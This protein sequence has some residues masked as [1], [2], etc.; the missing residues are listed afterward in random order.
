MTKDE[1]IQLADVYQ[2]RYFQNVF[3][4]RNC[5]AERN[6][7]RLS[8]LAWMT[9]H[10]IGFAE[11]GKLAKAERWIRFIQGALWAMGRTT[12]DTFSADNRGECEV[13]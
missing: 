5:D 1:V 4:V 13:L 10:L 12:Y 3:P 11:Q 8:H 2:E 6:P 9:A 7:T